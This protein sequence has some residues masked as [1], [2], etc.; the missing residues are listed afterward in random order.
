MQLNV[1]LSV[2]LISS[3]RVLVFILPSPIGAVRQ[4]FRS[5]QK[6]RE[7]KKIIQS[8]ES[9][10]LIRVPVHKIYV[11]GNT[12]MWMDTARLLISFI[13]INFMVGDLE[14][15][16]GKSVMEFI[17]KNIIMTNMTSSS[18]AD[19]STFEAANDKSSN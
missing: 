18:V 3:E 5:T 16:D 9:F 2:S 1:S 15:R 14:H 4:T 19:G 12:A 13:N 7:E 17:F 10:N 6:K 8:D 11:N